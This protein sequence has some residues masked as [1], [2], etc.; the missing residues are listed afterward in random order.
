MQIAQCGHGGIQEQAQIPCHLTYQRPLHGINIQPDQSLGRAFLF[1][2]KEVNDPD[3]Q[4]LIPIVVFTQPD[5][6][7]HP[8]SI[9]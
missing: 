3:T 1:K 7:R 5:A 6:H 4:L 9:S 2:P 8:V